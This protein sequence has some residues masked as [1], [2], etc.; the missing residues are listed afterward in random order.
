MTFS[1]FLKETDEDVVYKNIANLHGVIFRE[2]KPTEIR[3]KTLM[4]Y[5]DSISIKG[6]VKIT[7]GITM[8]MLCKDD[9]SV[10]KYI[11]DLNS[12]VTEELISAFKS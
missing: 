9:G 7:P 3:E 6:S 1:E 8:F 4:K 5:L 2:D 10:N 12:P 11:L